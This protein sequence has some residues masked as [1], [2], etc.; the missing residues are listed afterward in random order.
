MPRAT[1]DLKRLQHLVLLAE[2][3]NFSR[4]AERA[5][6]SQ[7]A[8]SRS[9]QSL[10]ADFGLRLFDRNTRSVRPTAA[11]RHLIARAKSLLGRARDMSDEIYY[12]AHAEA[13]ELNFGTSLLAIDGLVRQALIE[14]KQQSPK[15]KL[16]IEASQTP[17]LRQHLEQERIEFFVAYPGALELDERFLL[18]WL[19][20][21]PASIYCRAGHPL[22]QQDSPPAPSQVADYPWAALLLDE[23]LAPRLRKIFGMQPNQA[24]P[25][26]LSCDNLSLLRDLT[27]CSDNLLFTWNSWLKRGGRHDGLV[28]LGALLRPALSPADLRIDCAIVQ[29]ADRTL[30]PPA[31]RLVDL[32]LRHAQ[33]AMA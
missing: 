13:G 17:N 19:P 1:I 5:H 23:A 3:L 18:T 33:G 25:V 4:A 10:E 20:A 6:L 14:L 24:L 15:L 31:Q 2:E 9:I 21:E 26:G 27:L 32:I 7:T 11:G 29:L 30:S 22:L 8:Y 28:N 16:H 12:L